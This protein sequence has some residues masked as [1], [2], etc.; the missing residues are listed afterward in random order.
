MKTQLKSML[1]LM[2][3]SSIIFFGCQKSDGFVA[4]SARSSA[5]QTNSDG[6]AT[7]IPAWMTT[8]TVTTVSISKTIILK[9]GTYVGSHSLGDSGI[10]TMHVRFYDAALDSIHCIVELY[11][12]SGYKI[13]T[14]SH[15][16]IVTNLGLWH[17]IAGSGTGPY[18]NLQGNG[19]V[20]MM[21]PHEMA[22]GKVWK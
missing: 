8:T 20:V 16:S 14:G 11:P 22:T 10:Y 18:T 4:P 5:A 13:V 12:H 2:G 9:T 21:A 19:S 17:V 15:C 6:S 1:L 7:R 3:V